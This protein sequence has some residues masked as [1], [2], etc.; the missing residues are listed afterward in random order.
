MSVHKLEKEIIGTWSF[1]SGVNVLSFHGDGTFDGT[2][3]NVAANGTYSVRG[4]LLFLEF[5]SVDLFLVYTVFGAHDGGLY[6]DDAR[7]VNSW[8]AVI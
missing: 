7:S 5:E 6:T 8:D 3:N 4:D 1:E 2:F